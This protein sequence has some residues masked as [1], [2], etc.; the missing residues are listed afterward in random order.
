MLDDLA[1]GEETD[2][3]SLAK[4]DTTMFIIDCCEEI[5][6]PFEG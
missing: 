5:M 2:S 1:L 3:T 4:K 6:K